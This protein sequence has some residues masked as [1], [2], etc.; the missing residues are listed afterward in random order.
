MRAARRMAV[1]AALLM[2]LLVAPRDGA[3]QSIG[4]PV[5][6]GQPSASAVSTTAVGFLWES[7]PAAVTTIP[8]TR[9]RCSPGECFSQFVATKANARWQL[10]VKLVAPAAGFTVSLSAPTRP[11]TAT[12]LL[13]ATVWTPV[14]LTGEATRGQTAEVTYYGARVPGPAGRVPSATDVA[15]LLQYRLVQT[16]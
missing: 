8:R 7:T 12:A 4:G 5:I 2:P 11:A 15:T 14:Y 6:V 16:P 13:S 1:A 9:A 10:Q 3:A